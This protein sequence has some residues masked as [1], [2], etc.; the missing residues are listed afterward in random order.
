L[1]AKHYPVSSGVA[2]LGLQPD[3]TWFTVK[4]GGGQGFIGGSKDLIVGFA[5]SEAR[6][7]GLKR[8]VIFVARSAGASL[9]EARSAVAQRGTVVYYSDNGAIR[10]AWRA[11]IN[12]CLR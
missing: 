8:R 7:A 5:S 4:F 2:F 6:A 1:V 9:A 3:A 11:A 12:S 10:P